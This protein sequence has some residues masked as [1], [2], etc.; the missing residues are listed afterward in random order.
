[1]SLRF[2][3]QDTEG[4]RFEW[5]IDRGGKLSARSLG[6]QRWKTMGVNFSGPEAAEAYVEGRLKHKVTS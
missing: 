2:E 6:K 3:S 1:M 5:K 4:E